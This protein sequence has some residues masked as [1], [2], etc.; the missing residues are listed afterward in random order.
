[1]SRPAPLGEQRRAERPGETDADVAEADAEPAA[2]RRA[3][4]PRAWYRGPVLLLCLATALVLIAATLSGWLLHR[5]L[6][7]GLDGQ[8]RSASERFTALMDDPSDNDHDADDDFDRMVGP[9]DGT[10]GVVVAGGR[11]QSAALLGHGSAIPAPA[12]RRLIALHPE[13]G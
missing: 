12:G 5:S 2:A 4:E 3:P 11:L 10:L 1:M 13:R 8:V 9:V 6:L 7:G